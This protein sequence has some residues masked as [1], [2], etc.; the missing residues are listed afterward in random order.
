MQTGHTSAG[1][2]AEAGAII[3]LHEAEGKLRAFR[4]PRPPR[5]RPILVHDTAVAILGASGVGKTVVIARIASNNLAGAVHFGE[6][7]PTIDGVGEVRVAVDGVTHNLIMWDTPG[8]LTLL[9]TTD[10]CARF[11]LNTV[12]FAGFVLMF[13]VTSADSFQVCQIVNRKVMRELRGMPFGLRHIPR[14]LVGNHI[15]RVESGAAV[16]QVTQKE[17]QEY[18]DS[19]EI[20]YFECSALTGKGIRAPFD[21]LVRAAAKKQWA[22]RHGTKG[23]SPTAAETT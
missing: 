14:A 17:A 3:K 13:N 5:P 7:S 2:S 15:D 8:H 10:Q 21:A 12:G 22:D 20:P 9:G 16:R 6:Y 11:Q 23:P 1:P 4:P 19:L 18:A